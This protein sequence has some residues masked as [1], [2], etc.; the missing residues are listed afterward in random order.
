M[1]SSG[2]K[3]AQYLCDNSVSVPGRARGEASLI[4]INL[5]A[6]YPVRNPWLI[7]NVPSGSIQGDPLP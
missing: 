7:C 5:N 3:V 1:K 6:L 4:S 2:V